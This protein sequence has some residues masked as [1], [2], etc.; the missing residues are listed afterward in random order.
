MSINNRPLTTQ[1]S[2][3][4]PLSIAG[5]AIVSA[6][7]LS[8][9]VPGL[10]CIEP[11]FL[12]SCQRLGLRVELHSLRQVNFT[13]PIKGIGLAPHVG[14]PGIRTGLTTSAGL[15]FAAEGTADFRT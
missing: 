15:L 14:F 1:T 12:W 7:G 10:L 9:L 11:G 6:I 5:L 3:S 8:W 4:T 13:T 2:E